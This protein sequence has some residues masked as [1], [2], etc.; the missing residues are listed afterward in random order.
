[1]PRRTLSDA[2]FWLFAAWWVCLSQGCGAP[3]PSHRPSRSDAYGNTLCWSGNIAHGR[4][5]WL[6]EARTRFKDPFVFV[7]H[8]NTEDGKTWWAASDDKY[9]TAD[10]EAVGKLL[11]DLMPDRDVVLISCNDKAITPRLP[12]RV[13]YSPKRNVWSRPAWACIFEPPP[14]VATDIWEFREGSE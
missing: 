2:S 10:I 13:W 1:V 14:N 8:G 11:H 3:S 4:D 5:E 12:K 6:A 9:V 7:C